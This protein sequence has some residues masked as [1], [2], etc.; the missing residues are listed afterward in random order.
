MLNLSLYS[1][2]RGRI[3]WSVQIPAKLPRGFGSFPWRNENLGRQPAQYLPRYC[4]NETTLLSE[5]REV[6]RGLDKD[7][8]GK[9]NAS[10][11][12]QF[13]ES[14]N[15][16]VNKTMILQFIASEEGAR[17]ILS[18]LDT[19]K[20]GKVDKK[21]LRDFLGGPELSVDK[22]AIAQVFKRFDIDGDGKLDLEEI[23]KAFSSLS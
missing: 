14:R 5:L 16:K 2:G 23:I 15:V 20:D 12:R 9:A 21:E 13:F 11:L 4:W 6:L 8:N 10:E 17:R 7:N 19:D 18:V 22:S 3:Y 1:P